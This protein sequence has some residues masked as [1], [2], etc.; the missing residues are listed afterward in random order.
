[1]DILYSRKRLVGRTRVEK[2]AEGSPTLVE[3]K[4]MMDIYGEIINDYRQ[5]VSNAKVNDFDMSNYEAMVHDLWKDSQRMP[6]TN[7][8]RVSLVDVDTVSCFN[9]KSENPSISYNLFVIKI[10]EKT[11]SHTKNWMMIPKNFLGRPCYDLRTLRDDQQEQ[12]HHRF[13]PD[14]AFYKLVL[15]ASEVFYNEAIK[16]WC[17]LFL[18]VAEQW[19][20][21]LILPNDR[22]F[23]IIHHLFPHKLSA[24]N[25]KELFI[26]IFCML[27]E[28]KGNKKLQHLNDRESIFVKAFC[29]ICFQFCCTTH[30]ESLVDPMYVQNYNPKLNKKQKAKD[31]CGKFCY[32]KS[33]EKN[34]VRVLRHNSLKSRASKV[35]LEWTAEREEML[36]AL[37]SLFGLNSCHIAEC[38]NTPYCAEVYTRIVKSE[39]VVSAAR[40]VEEENLKIPEIP[41]KM[42]KSEAYSTRS[43]VN[44][45]VL[46]SSGSSDSD[47]DWDSDGEGMEAYKPCYCR[48]RCRDNSNCSCNER[49]Y[50]EKY[51][52]CSDNCSKR[53]L[54]CN[55]KGVCHRK[56]CLCMKN[57]RECDPTLCKNC[58]GNQLL[59]CKNDFMQNGIR[60]R[61][62]VCESN[63]H[64][65]GLFTTEDI[66]A[67][68]FI[69]EYRGEILTKA[70]AQRRGKIYDSRGM[71]FLFMLNTDFDLDA[72]RFGSVA[73]F[74]N[75]SK[76]PNCVPQVKMVLGSHRIAFY[77]TRNIEANEELFFNYGVLP[78]CVKLLLERLS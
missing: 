24:N 46:Y 16:F 53:Y 62:Y 3:T 55:C 52:R 69:C 43:C 22:L 13:L 39:G 35:K 23:T 21:E 42:F 41:K 73:R 70:E 7:E 58:G 45:K 2:S 27:N 78:E 67:G 48:G 33:L 49:E 47:S 74:I 44:S 54:G 12:N 51:C 17:L 26:H 37:E 5:P 1:M 71:S 66:V 15:K 61:L 30:G 25:L 75:H 50:C 36:R 72:T 29:P 63:V 4:M 18:D 34:T 76:I 77:A 9:E 20:G 28:K 57:N 56:V 38:L 65:L 14:F 8:D 31:P 19:S 60:R 59:I 64:G 6:Y 68:D 11:N 40:K 32:L 10:D